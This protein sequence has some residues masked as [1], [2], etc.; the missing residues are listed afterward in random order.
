[1]LRHGAK[2]VLYLL[3]LTGVLMLTPIFVARYYFVSGAPFIAITQREYSKHIAPFASGVPPYPARLDEAIADDLSIDTPI[4]RVFLTHLPDT[5]ADIE[6]VNERKRQ[7]ISTLLPLVLRANEL[8]AA[9]RKQAVSLRD[10][11]AR[12]SSLTP[13][14]K[15]WAKDQ[16]KRYRVSYNTINQA[17]LE[18]LLVKLD[19]V[20]PSLAITQAAIESGWGTSR[21]ALEGNALFG[22]WVWGD[23]EGLLPLNRDEGKDH[24][25]K[26]FQYLLDSVVSYMININRNSSYAELRRIRHDMRQNER[27]LTGLPLTK[28]LVLYS[29]RRESYVEDLQNIMEYNKLTALDQASL[30]PR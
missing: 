14:E 10:K 26:T 30:A 12:R 2:E 28:G 20:P 6:D 1:M 4:P 9:D 13:A 25:I 8:L 5:L 29:E 24:K 11:L 7:F 21:F 23:A 22:Q 27:T 3:T 17:V 15:A 19:I 16:L 18:K